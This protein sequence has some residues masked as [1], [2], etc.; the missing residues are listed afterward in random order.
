MISIF[1]S[2]ESSAPVQSIEA[3]HFALRRKMLRI[4]TILMISIG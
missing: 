4:E 1:N 3:A 2:L